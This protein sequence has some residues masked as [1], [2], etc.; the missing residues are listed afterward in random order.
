MHLR[1]CGTALACLAML[2]GCGRQ[3]PGDALLT[4]YQQRLAE[5]LDI[6]HPIPEPPANIGGFPDQDERLFDIPEIRE[7]LLDIYALR[8]CHITSLIARRNNQLG[9]VAAPSQRWLYELELWRRLHECWHSEVPESLAENDRLRLQRLT[10]TKTDQLPRASWNALFASSEWVGSFSRASSPLAPED[11]IPLAE[12]LE[13]LDYLRIGA[14]RQFDPD[15]EADSSTLE[16]HL[17]TLQREPL[18]ARILRSLMLA[19]LRLE[20]ANAMLVAALGSPPTCPL[21]QGDIDTERLLSI[22]QQHFKAEVHPYLEDIADKA[23]AWLEAINALLEAHEVSRPAV[24]D[25][26]Q[27]WL[28]LDNPEAPWPRFQEATQTHTR[29]WQRIR[30]TCDSPAKEG[31]A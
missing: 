8:E 13:A 5:A 20:E 4:D 18:T 14:E 29:H 17:K 9:R 1:L 19:S 2:L 16:G 3:G 28:S 15:W 10:E 31:G 12:S 11:E 30:R 24:A 23:R 26:R 27:A 25:Y 21:E 6:E 7:D 22:F